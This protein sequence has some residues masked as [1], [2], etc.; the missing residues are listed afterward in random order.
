MNLDRHEVGDWRG[1]DAPADRPRYASITRMLCN[2]KVPGQV[3]DV[4]CGTGL[5]REW[6]P[7][8]TAYLGIEPSGDAIRLARER[9]TSIQIIHARAEAF[10]AQGQRFDSIVFNEVLYYL[11]DP[12]GI[13]RKY[14]ALLQDDGTILCSVYQ[15]AGGV[16]LKRRMLHWLQSRRPRS[17]DHCITLVRRFMENAG[18]AIEQEDRVPVPGNASHWKVW[19]SRP[20]PHR[21][22][23]SQASATSGESRSLGLNPHGLELAAKP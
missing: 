18:W 2:G 5:L 10:D 17:N 15:K 9:D 13:L 3:L 7:P 22:S 23:V 1:L 14:A 8:E 19:L 12:V 20:Q 11:P 21:P 16:N 6:L 4:G